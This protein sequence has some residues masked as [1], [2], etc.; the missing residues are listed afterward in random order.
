MV[1]IVVI[2]FVF[3]IIL[4]LVY[5]LACLYNKD[6]N[7]LGGAILM[8]LTCII[9]LALFLISVHNRRQK[10]QTGMKF[11][12]HLPASAQIILS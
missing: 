5:L 11:P 12:N 6:S 3:F 2:I 10:N 7:I 9:L 8:L 4:G 1:A